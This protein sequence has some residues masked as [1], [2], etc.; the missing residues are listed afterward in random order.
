MAQVTITSNW[1]TSDREHSASVQ[2]FSVSASYYAYLKFPTPS[3]IRGKRVTNIELWIYVQEIDSDSTASAYLGVANKDVAE[4]PNGMTGRDLNISTQFAQLGAG[5]WRKIYGV[6]VVKGYSGQ[7][8]TNIFEYALRINAQNYMAFYTPS[9]QYKPYLVLTYEEPTVKTEGE[10]PWRGYINRH[11]DTTFGWRYVAEEEPYTVYAY[12]VNPINAKFR[13]RPQ[14]QSNYTESETTEKSYTVPAETF[15]GG[16]I[17]WQIIPVNVN[18]ELGPENEW[19][20][21]TTSDSIPVTTA[22][23]PKDVYLNNEEEHLFFWTHNVSTGTEQTAYDLEY[24]VNA[25]GSWNSLVSGQSDVQ[26]AIVPAGILPPGTIQ[27]RVRTYNVDGI[28]GEWSEP[29]QIVVYG[30][31]AAP[32]I[33]GIS[34]EARPMIEWQ[35]DAQSGYGLEISRDGVAV[36]EIP[37]R[38]GVEKAHRVE[39]YLEDGVYLVRLRIRSEDGAWSAWAGE[40]LTISTQKPDAPAVQASSGRYF[41]RIQILPG[42]GAVKYYL[43]RDGEPVARFE[44][45]EYL[46]YTALGPHSY[47]VRAVSAL[48]SFA[49]S[50]PAQAAVSIPLGGVLAPADAPDAL[51]ALTLRRGARPSVSDMLELSGE[52]VTLAGRLFPVCEFRENTAESLTLTFSLRKSEDREALRRLVDSRK[53]LLWRDAY[54][55]RCYGVVRTVTQA[56]DRFSADYTAMMDRVD[57]VER[58]R[59]DPPEVQD[60]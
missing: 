57:F 4:Y 34:N 21:L 14:G 42:S 52:L 26:S 11:L 13:W 35:A 18:G 9:S 28:S 38:Y 27:W 17:Q 30:P 56:R 33:T 55:G 60:A 3:E 32:Q 31:P 36:Y 48:D 45:T 8:L 6:P 39:E 5:A 7:V 47:V 49:D 10:Y 12:E 53:T 24:S 22:I 44:G 29:A 16:G 2:V 59:Y 37:E 54:G 19:F 20:N 40:G 1:G 46:D 41:A 15:P 50:A 23:S 51:M 43:L 25:G 58:I